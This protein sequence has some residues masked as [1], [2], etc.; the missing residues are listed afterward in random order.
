M[1]HTRTHKE[2]GP[3]G[4]HAAWREDQ[5]WNPEDT[6]RSQPENREGCPRVPGEQLL[7]LGT[8]FSRSNLSSNASSTFW[9]RPSA[10]S[11]DG[12]S[13]RHLLPVGYR[14]LPCKLQVRGCTRWRTTL[15]NALDTPQVQHY[16]RAQRL[17]VP[18][19]E[20]RLREF[21]QHLPR[22]SASP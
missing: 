18:A 3:E 9:R 8:G 19:R 7:E 6:A 15:T 5:G 13:A 4:E 16:R 1:A 17:R 11:G 22:V 12:A 2:G 10:E 20:A 21:S 14:S